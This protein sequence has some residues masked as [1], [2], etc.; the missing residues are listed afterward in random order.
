MEKERLTFSYIS[1]GT[2]RIFFI[3]C[4]LI[5][6]TVLNGRLGSWFSQYLLP[7]LL[8]SPLFRENMES[9]FFPPLSVFDS[10]L[11]FRK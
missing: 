6:Y 10:F 7:W 8:S 4:A 3:P 1:F 11:S 9:S 2:F 5:T